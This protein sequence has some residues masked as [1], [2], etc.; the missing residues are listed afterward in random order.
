MK[1]ISTKFGNLSRVI[2]IF[3]LIAIS[4]SILAVSF[5]YDD[6]DPEEF[7]LDG[8]E[9]IVI[10]TPSPPPA[11]ISPMFPVMPMF[12]VLPDAEEHSM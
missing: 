9:Q 7:R 2:A 6:S 3:V 10:S 11:P 1:N 12:P 4:V 5:A 8:V